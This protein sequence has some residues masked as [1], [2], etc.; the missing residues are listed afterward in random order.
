M[1]LLGDNSMAKISASS[2]LPGTANYFLGNDPSKWHS[3]V[4]RYARV[5]YQDVYPGVNLAF[6]G[7]QRQLEFDFVVAP[8]ANPAPIGFRFTGNQGMKTDDSG[9]LIIFSAAGDVLLHKPIAYQ[10][11]NGARQPVD[12]RFSL[13]A[14]NQ[15]AFELGNYD[16]NRELVIDPSVSYAYSTYLGGL[17]DDEGFGIAFDGNG[18]AYI[19]GETAST[20]FPT[21]V[22]G[23]SASNKGGGDDVFVSKIA[24]D[25]SSL[26]YSTYVGGGGI[27]SGNAIAVDA[28]GDAFVAGGTASTDFPTTSGAFQ[29]KIGSG[30]TGNASDNAF[31]FELN[32]SG[33]ALTYSTYLGGG[34]SDVAHGVAVDS[35][36]NA[37][38]AGET[39][40]SDFPTQ[41]PIQATLTGTANA[42]VTKLN[43][44]GTKLAY[45]TFLGGSVVDA[46][47]SI[48][49][50][51]SDNAYLTGS[52]TSLNFPTTT[53]AYQTACKSCLTNKTSN[54]F[55][56]VVN[57]AGTAYVYSTFLGG[58]GTD[59][60]TGIAVDSSGDAY[61]TGST[62]S[63][64]FP[65]QS[66][67]QSVY[68]GST[69]A[70]VTKLNPT[71]SALLYST[72]LGGSGF[73]AGAGIA[74]DT[75]GDAY[76]TGQ[77]SSSQTGLIAFRLANPIQAS[78]KGPSDA[79]VSEFNPSGSALIFSTY[80][81]GSLAEDLGAT[82]GIAVDK[83]GTF[84]Y[85]TGNT[86]STDFPL[87]SALQTALGSS[88]TGSSGGDAFVVKYSQ[89]PAF[90]M[91]ASTPAVVSPGGTAT[92]TITLTGYNTYNSPVNLTCTVSGAGAPLPACGTINPNPQ[93]PAGTPGSTSSV[94]ITTTGATAR[95]FHSSK[96]FYAMWLP[97]AG[98][99]LAGMGF[100]S[101]RSR[102][103]KLLGLLMIGMV[104]AALFLMPA[105][106][107]GS[108]HG[109]GGGGGGGCTGCTPA[110]AYTVTVSGT[111]T[112]ANKIT[113]HAQFTLTVN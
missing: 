62:T 51:S 68:G 59:V 85:V 29:T 106:G 56:T 61:L 78:L 104:M 81:G 73:D 32:S 10:E 9:N 84:I 35:S 34:V 43:P 111:G 55:V 83:P 39:F 92:S 3:G 46:A 108:S 14:N 74:I 18:N 19:T 53:G 100:S 20:N 44:S 67:L 77:T 75:A 6:Y 113:Q 31:V 13:Q 38:V 7:A 8:G 99:S 110:G 97:I 76:V 24:S 54:A 95:M 79:F 71:G 41:I 47:Q 16:H 96:F 93:T 33:S 21:V 5:S 102:R 98:M 70:F 27:D 65:T 37:Y 49:L 4:S 86:A 15:I 90:S 12:A 105:C 11:R 64:N 63:A 66:A 57:M 89:G 58:N 28:S 88:G 109:G 52:T 26:I 107:G 48:A 82:G 112:D 30:S 22:G 2:R 40:S 42:F 103:M 23:V 91:V 60:G 45:S 80:L 25:G 36:G 87:Q 69:D 50:D 72:Y 94:M 17:L 1:Q 101:A